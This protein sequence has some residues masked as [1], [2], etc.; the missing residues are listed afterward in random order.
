MD[1]RGKKPENPGQ[2][3]GGGGRSMRG[4]KALMVGVCGLVLTGCATAPPTPE[5]I[6]NNDPYE[7]TNRQMLVFN[8]KIDRYVVVPSV[9][10]YFVLVPDK[11]R[12]GV[13]NFLGNLSLP[14]IFVN[15][16]LQGEMLAAANRQRDSSSIPAWALAAFSTPPPRWEFPATARISARPWRSG[17]WAKDLIWCCPF[18]DLPIPA[19]LRGWG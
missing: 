6:A 17:A 3:P 14:T 16:I 13:H 4:I 5:E 9:A 1:R 7:Q 12:R 19:T 18:S 11:G 8:G 10:V 15:D 2:K